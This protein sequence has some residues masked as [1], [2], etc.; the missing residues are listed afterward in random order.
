MKSLQYVIG[1]DGGGTKTAGVIADLNGRHLFQHVSGPSNFQI[2][3]AEKTARVVLSIVRECCRSVG[4]KPKDVCAITIGLAGV[5]RPADRKKM[6]GALRI[7]SSARKFQLRKLRVES[8]ARIALE[9][10][11]NG[12]SGIVVIAG[13]GSVAFGKDDRGKVY[14]VGGWGRILGDEG[15]GYAIGKSALAAVCRY[16]DGRSAST[17]LTSMIKTKFKFR[18]SEQIIT[19]VYRNGF[20]LA[21]VAPLVMEAAKKGDLIARDI[22]ESASLE[23]TGH[24]RALVSKIHTKN[25][26][27][28]L[29]FIGGLI[30]RDTPLRKALRQHIIGSLPEV[31]IVSPHG[32]P[33][34]GAV[35]MSLS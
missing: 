33:L 10:A 12:G 18:T 27:I 17:K 28:Q 21:L 4:A 35:L 32:S 15:S 6:L 29:S 25:R 34:H 9:G 7:L 5:G 13:T 16:L 3:G 11:F 14:R 19:K 1:I 31:Q 30:G 24:V 22:V 2:I 8:D 20:D 23:L 26:G